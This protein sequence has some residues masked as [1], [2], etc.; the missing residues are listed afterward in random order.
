MKIVSIFLLGA[1]GLVAACAP[2]IVPTPAAGPTRLQTLRMELPTDANMSDLPRL[3]AADALRAQG[4]TVEAV[5][6][7]DNALSVQALEQGDLDLGY[8][9]NAIAWAAIKRGANIR[10]ILDDITDARVLAV[11][12]DIKTCADLN[13]KQV[14]VASTNSTQAI[15][16]NKYIKDECPDVKPEL[17]VMSSPNNR[18]I[19][20]TSGQVDAATMN[21]TDVLG[22]QYMHKMQVALLDDYTG[23]F[24][25]LRG[26][27][28]VARLELIEKYPETAKDIVRALLNARRQLQDPEAL[29]ANAVKYLKMDPEE[30]RELGKTYLEGQVWDLNGG[31]TPENLQSNLDFFVETGAVPAGL[32]ANDIADLSVMNAVLDELGRE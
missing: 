7:N 20:L 21:L 16:L 3:M 18:F 32:T 19:A 2:V 29:T 5:D 17:V 10:T 27:G 12:P 26:A 24:L 6:F 9:S 31:W 30:A 14:A 28:Q 8:I 15:L 1:M 11:A 22:Y 13:G 23:K 25:H 4:Y